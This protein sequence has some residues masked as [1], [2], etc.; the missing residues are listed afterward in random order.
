MKKSNEKIAKEFMLLFRF[1]PNNDYQPSEAEISAM[2]GQWGEFI[3]GIAI[4]EKLVS[5]HQLGFTG[6]QIFAD[7]SVKDGLCIADQQTMGGNMVIRAN[8]FT[9]AVDLAKGCPILNMGGRVEVRDIV[10]M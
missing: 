7:G 2:H 9:E 6:K 3:G 5:T 1:E 10:A 4:Q 8:S